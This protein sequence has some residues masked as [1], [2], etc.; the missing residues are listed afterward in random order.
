MWANDGTMQHIRG[1]HVF[2][3]WVLEG[4]MTVVICANT[5]CENNVTG[6]N[7]YYCGLNKIELYNIY[8]GKDSCVKMICRQEQEK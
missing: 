2:S 5:E 8:S 7:Y 1:S 4:E 6:D 3:L